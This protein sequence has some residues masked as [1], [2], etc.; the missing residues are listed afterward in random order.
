MMKSP[1]K[2]AWQVLKKL[3]I[4]LLCEPEI[5]LLLRHT[6]NIDLYESLY[7]DV[8]NSIIHNSPKIERIQ[9]D[10]QNVLYP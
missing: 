2:I 7:T 6:Y 4:K 1:W 8:Y 10:K 9:M 3:N 5:L